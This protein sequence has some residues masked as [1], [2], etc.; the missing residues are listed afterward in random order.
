MVTRTIYTLLY[1]SVR[2]VSSAH[3]PEN[4]RG[5][6]GGPNNAIPKSPSIARGVARM[7]VL[8]LGCPLEGLNKI[9]VQKAYLTISSFINIRL[10][11][12][13]SA[14]ENRNHKRFDSS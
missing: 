8:S 2:R 9:R 12:R 11:Y 5:V 7:A 13:A 6:V 3:L 14:S 4:K 1:M 10:T